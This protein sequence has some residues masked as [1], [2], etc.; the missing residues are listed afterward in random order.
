MEVT[1]EGKKPIHSE[2]G[3]LEKTALSVITA[4]VL[5]MLFWIGTNV[6]SLLIRVAVIET[7]VQRLTDDRLDY[8]ANLKALEDR[9]AKLE[10]DKH[11]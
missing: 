4:V 9:V 7:N 1:Q 3:T 5:G 11:E 8:N 6:S 2:L 10:G